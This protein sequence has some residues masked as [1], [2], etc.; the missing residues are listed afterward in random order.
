MRVN[1][2]VFGVIIV[3]SIIGNIWLFWD[4]A[5]HEASADAALTELAKGVSTGLNQA[6]DALNQTPI[7]WSLVYAGVAAADANGKAAGLMALQVYGVNRE[8]AGKMGDLHGELD[9][10]G[11]NILEKAQGKDELGVGKA[12][13]VFIYTVSV[14]RPL[15]ADIN[16]NDHY[17][18]IFLP[19]LNSFEQAWLNSFFVSDNALE[20]SQGLFNEIPENIINLPSLTATA[21][22]MGCNINISS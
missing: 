20:F 15:S 19:W 5:E 8:I 18:E 13:Q 9:F 16:N 11:S 17:L 22:D 3:I 12:V 6:R 10:C 7:D 2:Y 4:R 21:T 1:Q 14:V